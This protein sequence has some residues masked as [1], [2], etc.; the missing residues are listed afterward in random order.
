MTDKFFLPLLLIFTLFLGCNNPESS[1]PELGGSSWQLISYQL[2]GTTYTTDEARRPWL[3]FEADGKINGNTGCNSFGG[4]YSLDGSEL[5]T[6]QLFQTEMACINGMETEQHFMQLLQQKNSLSTSGDQLIFKST[7]GT[8]TFTTYDP[9]GQGNTS[10]DPGTSESEMATARGGTTDAEESE[11]SPTAYDWQV[12]DQTQTVS[13]EFAYMADAAVFIDCA[14]GERHPVAMARSFPKLESAY[15][16]TMGENVG[17]RAYAVLKAQYQS[18][19]QPDNLGKKQTLYVDEVVSL[20]RE[21][22]CDTEVKKYAGMY[23]YMADAALF[24]DCITGKRYPVAFLGAN[25]EM[26]NQY[27]RV[28]KEAGSPV[29]VEIEGFVKD[30]PT[31]EGD[32]TETNLI[33]TKVLG[34]IADAKCK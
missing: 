26:E 28:K 6:T 5:T 27:G 7:E 30:L 8:M 3:K 32:G 1:L 12:A 21:A 23:R 29:Y 16:K 2:D 17:Q 11:A 10:I 9:K 15:R 4:S 20:T 22:S 18:A 13:G 25:M 34:F 31:M 19:D 33:I 24:E 14:T